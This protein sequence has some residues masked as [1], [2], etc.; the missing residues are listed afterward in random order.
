MLRG[1]TVARHADTPGRMLSAGRRLGRY[2]VL[3][4]VGHGGMG[5]LYVARDEGSP[6]GTILA[7]KVLLP[8]LAHDPELVRMFLN[9]ARYAALLRHPNI[10]AVHDVGLVDG[11]HF[12]AMELVDG[13]D[14]RVLMQRVA[15]EGG[16]PL[17]VALSILVPI[18][19]ALHYAHERCDDH[20]RP[21][22]LVHRDVSPSNLVVGRDGVPK[23]VD[24]GLAKALRESVATKTGVLKGKLGYMAPEQLAGSPVDRRTDIFGMGVL[25]FECTTGRRLFVGDNEFAVMNQIARGQVPRP[26]T[27]VP[28]YLPGLEEIVLRA[29]ATDP[30]ARYPS[31]EALRGAL[32]E[33]CREQRIVLSTAS[34]AA[35]L[36]GLEGIGPTLDLE[37]VTIPRIAATEL[38]PAPVTV[39]VPVLAPMIVTE[40]R[41]AAVP[42]RPRG[43]AGAK[44]AGIGAATLGIGLLAAFA[45]RAQ[46]PTTTREPPDEP[47]PAV[48]EPSPAAADR[49]DVVQ[50]ASAEEA[51]AVQTNAEA[52]GAEATS[53]EASAVQ[54]S[55]EEATGGD[56][57]VAIEPEP[58]PAAAKR[59]RRRPTHR[60]AATAV[61]PRPADD[62]LES[63]LPAGGR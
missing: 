31:A 21:L 42:M 55:A 3:D 59:R 36:A 46:A 48:V 38:A 33:L 43:R 34:V 16:L 52:T 37:P 4:R 56:E 25:L 18:A 12:I 20:G 58:A 30:R 35:R 53:V 63:L 40:V 45:L 24:F 26:T 28:G 29:L 14:L 6:E 51:S 11:E 7:L 22:G 39:P 61:R 47:P 15:R 13:P 50:Q 1:M 17:D 57:S 5:E 23:L 49:A 62:P 10:A 32:V 8:H 27:L 19:A 44:L 2:V 60:P 41:P 54:T 9:E